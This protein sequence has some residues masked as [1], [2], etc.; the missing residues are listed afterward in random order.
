MALELITSSMRVSSTRMGI[1]LIG[2]HGGGSFLGYS[3]RRRRELW[4]ILA[5]KVKL[6]PVPET[7]TVFTVTKT[8]EQGATKILYKW[9][10]VADKLDEDLFIRVITQAGDGA[11]K[12]VRTVS[13]SY[14][15]LSRWRRQAPPNYGRKF[16]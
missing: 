10:Q 7:V 8:L 3:R 6:V 4:V 11:K 13:N 12:G 9:Q 14:N 2:N 15:A 1:F 5:W 16:S